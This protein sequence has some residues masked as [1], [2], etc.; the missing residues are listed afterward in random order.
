MAVAGVIAAFGVI[1]RS[2]VLIVGAMAGAPTCC[3]SRPPPSASWRGGAGCSAGRSARCCPASRPPSDGVAGH[4]GSARRRS[5]RRGRRHLVRRR[6]QP[7]SRLS[8]DRR[9]GARR[10]RRRHAELR[11]ARKLRRRRRHLGD[12]DPGG[13]LHG[14][15]RRL[16]EWHGAAG[17]LAVLGV[18]LA[19]LLAAGTATLAMQR[20]TSTTAARLSHG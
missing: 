16:G 5:R 7:R 12:D 11:D 2:A 1:D 18:N 9:G 8:H 14:R 20:F 3:R 17:A 10:R 13:G 4:R 19:V 15:R 6:L